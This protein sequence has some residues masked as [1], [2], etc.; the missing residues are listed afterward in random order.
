MSVIE[1]AGCGKK[2]ITAYNLPIITT[3]KG[4]CNRGFSDGTHCPFRKEDMIFAPGDYVQY[5]DKG[6]EALTV[7]MYYYVTR[8][9]EGS[10][11]F[12]F[13]AS[14]RGGKE[15]GSAFPKR[16]KKAAEPASTGKHGILIVGAVYKVHM[17][18]HGYMGF[19]RYRDDGFFTPWFSRQEE[20]T[21][22]PCHRPNVFSRVE[23]ID[24][25]DWK[26]RATSNPPTPGIYQVRHE[27]HRNGTTNQAW[28]AYWNGSRWGGATSSGYENGRKYETS[29]LQGNVDEWRECAA[30]KTAFDYGPIGMY[31]VLTSSGAEWFA[32]Y[33]GT[34]FGNSSTD[35]SNA[36]N[37]REIAET[38]PSVKRHTA[39][40]EVRRVEFKVPVQI[41]DAALVSA[42][43]RREVAAK[44]PKPAGTRR[45]LLLL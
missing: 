4:S 2:D 35:K 17:D 15:V 38:S 41:K 1:C 20:I 25:S 12:V 5:I 40:G 29:N 23:R 18:D 7:G 22:T 10:D 21:D 14:T 31:Q 24:G 44:R 19:A 6:C 26:A 11:T 36:Y 45:K 13:V 28:Y 27:Q 39:K 43:P 16:F 8:V 9:T 37:M 32:W 33:D 42:E 30:P 3:P 34:K